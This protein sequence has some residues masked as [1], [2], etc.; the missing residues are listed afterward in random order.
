MPP[1]RRRGRRSP[2]GLSWEEG[3]STR[4]WVKNNIPSR[5]FMLRI[6][7]AKNL[8]IFSLMMRIYLSPST[9]SNAGPDGLFPPADGEG[10]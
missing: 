5:G 7:P 8:L 1:K 10:G 9:L 4:R 3:P 2:V 6:T